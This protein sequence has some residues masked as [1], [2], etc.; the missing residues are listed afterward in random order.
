MH[1]RRPQNAG[2]VSNWPWQPGCIFILVQARVSW[3][4]V[5]CLIFREP[6]AK[7]KILMG[8]GLEGGGRDYTPPAGVRKMGVDVAEDR[9]KPFFTPR[10]K[11]QKKARHR[12]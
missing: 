6:L 4:R 11:G 9:E 1:P 3:L 7:C 12:H 8:A 5:V 2:A 10:K